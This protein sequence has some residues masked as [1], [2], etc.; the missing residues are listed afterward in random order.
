MFLHSP[1][2]IVNRDLVKNPLPT[3]CPATAPTDYDPTTAATVYI[4]PSTEAIDNAF[5]YVTDI[6]QIKPTVA[7]DKVHGCVAPQ[8]WDA[9]MEHCR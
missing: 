7:E 1:S 9:T 5:S 6:I 2:F 4:Y 3:D 8:K